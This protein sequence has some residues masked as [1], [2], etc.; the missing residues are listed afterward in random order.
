MFIK[1]IIQNNFSS[2]LGLVEDALIQAPGRPEFE[3][4]LRKGVQLEV[5]NGLWSKLQCPWGWPMCTARN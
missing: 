2:D 3:D 5:K 4:D 1:P